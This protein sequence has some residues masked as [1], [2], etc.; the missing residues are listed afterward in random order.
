[1]RQILLK[2]LEDIFNKNRPGDPNLSVIVL[3][4]IVSKR[5]GGKR[6]QKPLLQSV[7]AKVTTVERYHHP[8]VQ[9]GERLSLGG[10]FTSDTSVS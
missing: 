8:G 9:A 5:L 4:A 1:M 6:L 7:H 2:A 3:D 10:I